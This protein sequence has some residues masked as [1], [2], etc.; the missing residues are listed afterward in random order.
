MPYDRYGRWYPGYEG[1]V[2]YGEPEG[3]GLGPADEEDGQEALNYRLAGPYGIAREP[4]PYQR[5]EGAGRGRRQLRPRVAP[6]S[7]PYHYPY[8]GYGYTGY[9]QF[10]GG[11]GGEAE[12]VVSSGQGPYT[13]VGPRT[14]VR[15]D[16][17]IQEDVNEALT[18]DPWLDPTDIDV[19]VH[20]GVVTLQGTVQ[21]RDA[22]RR[23]SEDAWHVRGVRDV[24]NVLRIR[25]GGMTVGEATAT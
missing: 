5:G 9:G 3:W 16:D 19:S 25:V 10:G 21:S 18:Q 4:R 23:A 6:V 11:Y 17:R 7:H 15:S 24:R 20:N 1:P 14:Y 2:Q 22:R 13:G 12:F 8:Y